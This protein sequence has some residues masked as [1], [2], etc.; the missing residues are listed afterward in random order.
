LAAGHAYTSYIDEEGDQGNAPQAPKVGMF[1]AFTIERGNLWLSKQFYLG[2]V[3][4][5]R[6]IAPSQLAEDSGLSQSLLEPGIRYGALVAAAQQLAKDES[7]GEPQWLTEVV[8]QQRTLQ[9]QLYLNH[10]T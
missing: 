10:D 1:T 9:G 4:S 2:D 8:D 7:I 6:P 5:L 3:V